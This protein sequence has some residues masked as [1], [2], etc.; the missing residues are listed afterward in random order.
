VTILL[1]TA[2]V[3]MVAVGLVGIVMPALPGHLLILAGLALAAWADGFHHVSGWTL[4]AIAVVAIA[5]YGIDFV[6]AAVSTKKLGASKHAMAGAA[7]GTLGGL[8]FG[9]P[10]LI[11]GPFVGAVIG[12]LIA[13]KD[14]RQAGRA[15]V[16]ATIGFAIGTA[17][18]VAF[19][20][21][22]IAIFIAAFLF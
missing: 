7:L 22:M 21:V 15:G 19:A 12:E 9:L 14:L 1:W 13:T 16:A 10:G 6:A 2:A 20:F 18:K 17:V 11:A 8:F 5:S 3:A 4:G